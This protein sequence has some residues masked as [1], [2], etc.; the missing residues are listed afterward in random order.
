MFEKLFFLKTWVDTTTTTTT[1]T[2]KR[3]QLT[4]PSWYSTPETTKIENN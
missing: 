4:K 2:K 1:T 3:C